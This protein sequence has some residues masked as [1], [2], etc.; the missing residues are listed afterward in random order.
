MLLNFSVQIRVGMAA[1]VK[2]LLCIIQPVLGFSKKFWT[3]SGNGNSA[4]VRCPEET[5]RHREEQSR[6]RRRPGES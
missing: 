3:F 6:D 4:V 1:A 2:I 5:E